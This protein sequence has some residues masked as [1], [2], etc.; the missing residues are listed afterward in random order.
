MNVFR[1]MV[2]ADLVN[3]PTN[4]TQR[5]VSDGVN[6]FKAVD[7]DRISEEE[8]L[9]L[10]KMYW[11]TLLQDCLDRSSPMLCLGFYKS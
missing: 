7:F 5:H 3:G 9:K 1:L 4:L 8:I 6:L 10:E 2:I 11:Y